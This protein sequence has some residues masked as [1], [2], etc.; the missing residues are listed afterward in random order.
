[1]TIQYDLLVIRQLLTCWVTLYTTNV[2]VLENQA[3]KPLLCRGDRE[4]P[5]G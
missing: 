5:G 3:L 4:A 1:M 2:T